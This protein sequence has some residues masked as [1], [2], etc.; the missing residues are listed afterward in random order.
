MFHSDD[1]SHQNTRVPSGTQ[2]KKHPI[3]CFLALLCQNQ[4]AQKAP[5]PRSSYYTEQNHCGTSPLSDQSI[6]A[7][8]VPHQLAFPENQHFD[9]ENLLIVQLP[10]KEPHQYKVHPAIADHIPRLE[11][12]KLTHVLPDQ[13]LMV[14]APNL[15]ADLAKNVKSVGRPSTM[16]PLAV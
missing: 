4:K 15:S 13:T 10:N 5:H 1:C 6:P 16:E 12:K 7:S 14:S 2:H 9:H 8:I 3:T 11:Q